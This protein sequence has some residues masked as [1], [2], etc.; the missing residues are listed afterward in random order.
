MVI[1]IVILIG[2]V[3]FY[4]YSQQQ[5]SNRNIVKQK[6]PGE[7][8]IFNPEIDKEGVPP[9]VNTYRKQLNGK[10]FEEIIKYVYVA[11][12]QIQDQMQSA[13]IFMQI[14]EPLIELQELKYLDWE[15]VQYAQKSYFEFLI[16][17]YADTG[18][19]GQLEN[20][21]D[22]YYFFDQ[23]IPILEKDLLSAFHKAKFRNELIAKLK[24]EGQVYQKDLKYIQGYN[25]IEF[26][27][28]IIG[29]LIN[30]NIIKRSKEGRFVVFKLI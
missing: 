27:E 9:I 5:G 19:I 20:V 17:H 3:L 2:A 22:L 30:S 21:K 26:I 7:N 11:T 25:E 18:A 12:E 4:F 14:T 15:D 29:R 8:W 6:V 23:K 1:I 13:L 28:H 16:F 10:T 24:K